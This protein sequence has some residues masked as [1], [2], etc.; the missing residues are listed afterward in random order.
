MEDGAGDDDEG[1][2][3]VMRQEQEQILAVLE[4]MG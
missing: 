4:Q 1:M 3:A 2:E